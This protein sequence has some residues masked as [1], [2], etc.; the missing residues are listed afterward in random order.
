MPPEFTAPD[1]WTAEQVAE[2]EAEWERL[3]SDP[4]F[5]HR[6]RLLPPGA[7]PATHIA[8]AEV[9]VGSRLRQRCAWC[10]EVMADYDLQRIAVLEGDDPRPAM[11]LQGSLVRRDGCAWFVVD[12]EEGADLPSDSC[13]AAE[14]DAAKRT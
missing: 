7:I 11:W 2:F 6:V 9:Q 14:I 3:T 1:T 5:G 8:G 4:A 12:H 10:G 13:A